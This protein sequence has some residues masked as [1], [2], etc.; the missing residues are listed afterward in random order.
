M[1]ELTVSFDTLGAPIQMSGAAGDVEWYFRARHNR[2]R[3]EVEGVEVAAGTGDPDL[4]EC[5][6]IIVDALWHPHL[7]E[8]VWRREEAAETAA[9]ASY[10]GAKAAALRPHR[11]RSKVDEYAKSVGLQRIPPAL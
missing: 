10:E 6:R 7:R 5:V 2:W 9:I 1:P 4:P 8:A 11:T 3:V